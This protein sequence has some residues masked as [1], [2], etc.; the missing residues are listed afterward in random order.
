MDED[1]KVVDAAK[2]LAEAGVKV[3]KVSLE[4]L[5]DHSFLQWALGHV[6]IKI[7]NPGATVPNTSAVDAIEAFAKSEGTTD[8][9]DLVDLLAQIDALAIHI[10]GLIIALSNE[11]DEEKIIRAVSLIVGVA[12]IATLKFGFP[13]THRALQAAGLLSDGLPD[14]EA[15]QFTKDAL[16]DLFNGDL[17][18]GDTLA[19]AAVGWFTLELLDELPGN[20][21]GMLYGWEPDPNTTTPIVDRISDRILSVYAGYESDIADLG[22]TL[23][24]SAII[25]P[26]SHGGPGFMF[27]LGGSGTVS[28]P[29]D[30][31]EIA[32]EVSAPAPGV[33]FIG[34]DSQAW[35]EPDA[36]LT[37]HLRPDDDLN[38]VRPTLYFGASYLSLGHMEVGFELGMDRQR[39]IVDFK[40]TELYLKAQEDSG[41]FLN[42]ILPDDGMQAIL[43]FGLAVN[44][45]D[46]SVSLSEGTSLKIVLPIGGDGVLGVRISYLI[47]EIGI[48]S[49][50]DSFATVNEISATFDVKW[51]GFHMAIERM[52]LKLYLPPRENTFTND[53]MWQRVVDFKP[54]TGLGVALDTEAVSGG[55]YL[56]FDADNKEWGGVL[57]LDIKEVI[58]ITVLGLIQD[59]LPDAPDDYALVLL[60][61]VEFP[62]PGLSTFPNV[63]I[64]GLGLLFAHNRGIDTDVLRQGI[65]TGLVDGILFPSDP[66]ANAP[67]II[68][69]M[70]RLFPVEQGR[71]AAG[72]LVKLGFGGSGAVSLKLGVALEWPEPF[73]LV[74]MGN[75]TIKLPSQKAKKPVAQVLADFALIWDD[76]DNMISFD[77]AL[78]DS[79][80]AEVYVITGEMAARYHYADP[81]IFVLSVGGYH[82]AFNASEALPA[83][84]QMPRVERVSIAFGT[85]SNPRIRALG[86]LAITPNS[87]QVGVRAEVVA[88]KSGFSLEGWI[89][90]DALFQ[91]DP[92]Y[93]VIDFSAGVR[94]KK[95]SRTLFSMTLE[96]RL[97]GFTP[98]RISGRVKF[99]VL[100][101]TVKIR[102]SLTIGADTP[103]FGGDVD[104]LPIITDALDED[105]AWT[106]VQELGFSQCA[107]LQP[108]EAEQNALLLHPGLTLSV[109]QN[110]VP[111]KQT[112]DLFYGSRIRNDD[113]FEIKALM[114][115]DEEVDLV[116][117]QQD[118]SPA[119]FHEMSDGEKL[120]RPSFEPAPAGVQDAAPGYVA[121]PM[122]EADMSYET[123]LIDARSDRSTRL[124]DYVIDWEMFASSQTFNK[125][126]EANR[127]NFGS[128]PD[129]IVVPPIQVEPPGFVVATRDRIRLADAITAQALPYQEAKARLDEHLQEHPEHADKLQILAAHQVEIA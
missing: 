118:F 79:Y 60:G 84:A 124:D 6:G 122:V 25:V 38:V 28:I 93:F 89:G 44:L 108:V 111:L 62:P 49:E 40:K 120:S 96:G 115:A 74:I 125:A 33:F 75:L 104:L 81:K 91:F 78:R 86:Y 64:E 14:Y 22:A 119:Q 76:G 15:T 27:S 114:I 129:S 19:L 63:Y 66:V 61:T 99:K 26:E 70:R 5:L 53:N 92:F 57:H 65:K 112:L 73:V 80:V 90:V 102:V 32:V 8:L 116:D 10:R 20:K 52:G 88:K 71:Q 100:F 58:A 55:G 67:Q 46:G 59:G 1:D 117:V 68:N 113:R 95:G 48:D 41:S 21:S 7:E 56:F 43:N 42:S 82:P 69:D 101:V 77:A 54:P 85:G 2:S 47:I 23:Q 39:L 36:T 72:L 9:A 18:W 126:F 45:G 24:T 127:G 50:R 3:L 11:D 128:E 37:I 105:A 13:K 51:G 29:I 97:E 17:Q 123:I 34:P 94:I 4:L 31:Y 106:A 16:V 30:R 12:L 109:Q 98:T 35:G 110:L 107:T 103:I 87:F 83:R 121:G